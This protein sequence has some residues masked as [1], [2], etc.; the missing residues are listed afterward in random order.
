MAVVTLFSQITVDAD[1]I[2]FITLNFYN[3]NLNFF[4][5]N[6][7]TKYILII[8]FSA[9]PISHTRQRVSLKSCITLCCRYCVD[10]PTSEENCCNITVEDE[11]EVTTCTCYSDFC[12][13]NSSLPLCAGSLTPTATADGCQAPTTEGSSITTTLSSGKVFQK[14]ATKNSSGATVLCGNG[15]LLINII[16]SVMLVMYI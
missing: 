4:K 11:N 10:I 14:P 12:N 13:V 1:E 8:F 7:K 15:I 9:T 16:S 5:R 2:F 6:P 3:V